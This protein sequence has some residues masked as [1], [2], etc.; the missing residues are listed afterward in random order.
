MSIIG[1]FVVLMCVA[2]AVWIIQ[3]S[4]WPSPFSWG[5]Y[6]LLFVIVLFILLRVS[7]VDLG[8]V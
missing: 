1:I 3:S 8:H 4:G 2:I 5:A 6:G 7:G